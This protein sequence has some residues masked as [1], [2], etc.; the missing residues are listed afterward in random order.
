MTAPDF[1]VPQTWTD[2]VEGALVVLR[3]ILEGI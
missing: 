3:T 1:Q 2:D